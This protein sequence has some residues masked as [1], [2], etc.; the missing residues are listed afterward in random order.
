[1]STELTRTA[2][3]SHVGRC[4]CSVGAKMKRRTRAEKATTA[5]EDTD[6]WIVENTRLW[7]HLGVLR[8]LWPAAVTHNRILLEGRDFDAAREFREAWLYAVGQ[9]HDLERGEP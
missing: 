5:A 2:N 8:P 4:A 9:V 3:A 6:C 7:S 1:M